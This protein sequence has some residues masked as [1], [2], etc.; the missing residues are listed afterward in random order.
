M[1]EM[2]MEMEVISPLSAHSAVQPVSLCLGLRL[3][4]LWRQYETAVIQ[5]KAAMISG[6]EALQEQLLYDVTGVQEPLRELVLQWEGIMT[7]RQWK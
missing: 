7:K 2:E 1:K 3:D 6:N 4:K 5:L